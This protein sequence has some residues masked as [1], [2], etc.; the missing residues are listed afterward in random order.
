MGD[1]QQDLGHLQA[2][3]ASYTEALHLDRQLTEADD[4]PVILANLAVSLRKVA[5][6]QHDLGDPQAAQAS[7]TEALQVAQAAGM[8]GMDETHREG[9]M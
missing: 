9:S 3:L 4:S 8:E 5:N 1:V 2:A 7:Y 6:V